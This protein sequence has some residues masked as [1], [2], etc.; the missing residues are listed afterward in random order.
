M[1][2]DRVA[3]TQQTSCGDP[4]CEALRAAEDDEGA[5]D[6]RSRAAGAKHASGSEGWSE[7]S[8]GAALPRFYRCSGRR[9]DAHCST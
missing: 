8:H 4:L 3:L 7:L 2:G 9:F 5:S 6:A 1:V